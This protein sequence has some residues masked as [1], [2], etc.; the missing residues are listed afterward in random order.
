[1]AAV[2]TLLSQPVSLYQDEIQISSEIT[3]KRAPVALISE[4]K[5]RYGCNQ[6]EVIAYG[7]EFDRYFFL[8]ESIYKKS[9]DGPNVKYNVVKHLPPSEWNYVVIKHALGERRPEYKA[10]LLISDLHASQINDFTEYRSELFKG[11]IYHYS[12]IGDSNSLLLANNYDMD[13]MIDPIT[14]TDAMGK[15]ICD[16]YEMFMN[17]T[18]KQDK[19]PDFKKV[20]LDFIMLRSIPQTSPLY[21]LSIISIIEYLLVRESKNISIAEQLKQKVKFLNSHSLKP[22]NLSIYP[23][24]S[25]LNMDKLIKKLYFYRSKIAHG[26]TLD[27]KGKLSVLKSQRICIDIAYD[28]LRMIIAAYAKEPDLVCNIKQSL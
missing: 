26:D 18:D 4:L 28:I 13:K 23:I 19:Y 1:M 14:Y 5:A 15:E 25:S 6:K 24:D 22:F 11:Q 27:F 3:I 10:A 7:D 9:K 17:I 16:F 2:L 12:M 8:F 20:L 21:F